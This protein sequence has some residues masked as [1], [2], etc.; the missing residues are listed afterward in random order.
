[1]LLLF[2]TVLESTQKFHYT[3]MAD[4]TGMKV[5]GSSCTGS[6]WKSDILL[7]D[8]PTNHLDL[9]AIRMA[10]EFLINPLTTQSSLYHMTVIS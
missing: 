9:P 1:M 8:E 3:Q 4:L 6:F 5:K 2:S 7:L 10:G